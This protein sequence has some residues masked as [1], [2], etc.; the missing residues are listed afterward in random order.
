MHFSPPPII[1]SLSKLLLYFW[2]SKMKKGVFKS[3]LLVWN[4]E[5][6]CLVENGMNI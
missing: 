4:N 5:M 2:G 6:T 1:V 3:M